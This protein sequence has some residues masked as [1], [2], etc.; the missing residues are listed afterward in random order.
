MR[1]KFTLITFVLIF[2]CSL[3]LKA[4]SNNDDDA[5]KD[6][7]INI[8][9]IVENKSTD[10]SKLVKKNVID[11]SVQIDQYSLINDS[12]ES[13]KNI[14]D[15]AYA[16]NLD[17]ILKLLQKEELIDG[18]LMRKKSSWLELFFFSTV[19]KIFFWLVGCLFIGFILQRL[20]FTEGFFQHRTLQT[21][22]K[23]LK[24]EKEHLSATTDYLKLI[25][26]SVSS[27]NYRLAV[28]YHYLQTL[29][30]LSAKGLILFSVDKT[31][32]QYITELSDKFYKNEFLRL[33]K[34]Y[35]YIWYGGFV[36]N[37]IMY[38]TIELNFKNFNDHL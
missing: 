19:T 24:E 38:N 7:T 5:Y 23:V 31:N 15:F 36:T 9:N 26:Q 34:A 13:L 2:F 8:E 25:H 12:A 27:E 3:L 37:L 11:T 16:K 20:F 14:S 32:H 10:P 30:K 22:V 6:S 21:N 18:K 35:E 4:Q 29:Q 1:S 33:T 17:S 28:R